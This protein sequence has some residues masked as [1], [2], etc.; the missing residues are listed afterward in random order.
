MKS[1]SSLAAGALVACSILPAQAGVAF[2]FFTSGIVFP[3]DPVACPDPFLGCSLTAIGSSTALAGN[4]APLPGP[5]NFS[6]TFAIVAPLS[7]TTFRTTGVFAFDDPSAA[8]NDLAGSLEG[9]LDATTF[10]NDMTYAVTSGSGI[11]AGLTGSG[12]SRIQIIPQGPADPFAFVEQGSMHVP[13]PH[14]LALALLGLCGVGAL[15]RRIARA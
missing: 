10:T 6:A 7:A 14:S 2:D 1:L 9:V 11:F 5:W 4:V 3:T 15:R 12:S 8:D 13:E